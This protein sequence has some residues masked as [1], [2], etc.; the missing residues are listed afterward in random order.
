MIPNTSQKSATGYET[1]YSEPSLK[2]ARSDSSTS[3]I[4][5]IVLKTIQSN[6]LQLQ[7]AFNNEKLQVIDK[8]EKLKVIKLDKD[9]KFKFS[10]KFNSFSGEITEGRVGNIP[11]EIIAICITFNASQSI[12]F[13]R[14]S[15]IKDLDHNNAGI[16]ILAAKVFLACERLLNRCYICH[17]RF[18]GENFSTC[19]DLNEEKL[20]K[21][22][23]NAL[24]KKIDKLWSDLNNPHV[25]PSEFDKDFL[26]NMRHIPHPL[27]S[28]YKPTFNEMD[29]LDRRLVVLKRGDGINRYGFIFNK[30]KIV[31][32]FYTNLIGHGK[33][34]NDE[35]FIYQ[36]ES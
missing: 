36:W 8:N 27:D 23:N 21:L 3:P 16:S 30:N 34:L 20:R 11:S 28:V 17:T 24:N 26:V 19:I 4:P 7:S 22:V 5:K 29:L 15:L 18:N 12:S 35:D 10:V 14:A 2:R 9:D 1:L 6:L 32:Q 33:D 25:Y 31:V 13:G